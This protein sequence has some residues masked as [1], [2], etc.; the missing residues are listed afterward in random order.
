M[1][2][3][4]VSIEI[5]VRIFLPRSSWGRPSC[6]IENFP[7]DKKNDS[8]VR[9]HWNRRL[10]FWVA[11]MLTPSIFGICKIVRWRLQGRLRLVS[12]GEP[13]QPTCNKSFWPRVS[14]AFWT[15]F[16]T[17]YA[18][19]KILQKSEIRAQKKQQTTKITC[20]LQGACMQHARLQLRNVS[21]GGPYPPHS[22]IYIYIY[23]YTCVFS[24]QISFLSFILKNIYL[25]ITLIIYFSYIF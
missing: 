1:T 18:F 12:I 10:H 23:I 9:I 19:P 14:S 5:A 21:G 7:L 25:F 17:W 24:L 4:Y 11:I 6:E 22:N 16:S 8:P 15:Q 2:G 3:P 13:H 20:D